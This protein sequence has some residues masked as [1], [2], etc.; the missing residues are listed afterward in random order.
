MA[1]DRVLIISM[2]LAIVAIVLTILGQAF[3]QFNNVLKTVL[4]STKDEAYPEPVRFR[5]IA[6]AAVAAVIAAL[7]LLIAFLTR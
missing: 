2:A 6:R 1:V 3:G 7:C 5:V 4:R